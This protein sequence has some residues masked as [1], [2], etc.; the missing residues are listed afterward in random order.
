MV[1]LG[2]PVA[3]AATMTVSTRSDTVA[4]DGAC[5]LREA[6][7]A[8]ET[9]LSS[10][11]AAG[12]CPAGSGSDTIAL[13][14]GPRYVLTGS[15]T[16]SGIITIDGAGAGTTTIDGG[17]VGRVLD[18]QAGATVRSVRWRSPGVTRPTAAREALAI[19]ESRAAASGTPGR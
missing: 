12:E 13:A 10:G 4:N 3:G 5:S 15:L 6:L 19:R 9:R 8:A 16:V 1:L 2:A 14:A 7:T 11:S 18:I 17:G